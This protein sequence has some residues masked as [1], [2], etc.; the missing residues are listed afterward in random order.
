MPDRVGNLRLDARIPG[1]ERRLRILGD[2]AC[3]LSVKIQHSRRR[4]Q[5]AGRLDP[6]ILTALPGHRGGALRFSSC[7]TSATSRSSRTSTT[8]SR[9]SPIASSSAAAACPTA[10][11]SAQVLD[12]MDLERERGITIKAQT[13]ALVLQRARRRDVP[14]QPDRHAGPR[15]LRLRGVALARR[16]RGRAAGRRRVA[17]R[18]G[19]DGRQ[20][21][22]GDRAGR[23]GRAG[24]E[25][26][27][28]AVGGARARDRR[29]RGHHRHRRRR[30][31]CRASAKTGEGID[32]ILEAVI[33]RMPPPK[34][35]P[36]GAAEGAASSTRGST[37][38]SASSCSCA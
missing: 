9:R 26:D 36:D 30:T 19:A 37:T 14:A 15:R 4:E 1:T 8:A 33:A 5:Q 31:P 24:A 7:R 16:V 20:L 34:G 6:P 2:H 21:L 12:S 32:D 18:R 25:Q 23:R 11:W 38:T 17:G 10:R 29:D 22:H 35:D 3:P 28:P 13:A 27:R